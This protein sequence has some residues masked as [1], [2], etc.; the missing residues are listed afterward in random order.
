MRKSGL[1]FIFMLLCV[2]AKSQNTTLT[3]TVKLRG[4]RLTYPLVR[5]WITAFKREFPNVN[6]QIAQT[7]PADSIDL[8]LAAHSIIAEDLKGN[9]TYVAISRYVQLP[10]VN[11]QNPQLKQLQEKGF[12]DS[13]F[14]NIYFSSGNKSAS[15][16]PLPI[17]LYNRERPTCA[18]ITVARHF[19]NDDNALNGKPVKGDDQDL[20]NAVKSDVNGISFNNLGFIYDTKTRKVNEGI[21]VIPIDLN[22]SGK[23]DTDES[24]YDNLDQVISFVE[25]TNNRKFIDEHVNVI[26]KRDLQNQAA[27]VFLKWVLEK[28]QQYNHGKGFLDLAAETLKDQQQVINETFKLSSTSSCNDLNGVIS[29]RKQ[30][31]AMVK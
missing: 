2:L 22:D 5:D 4:T 27:G 7:A 25:K 8:Q 3:G 18:T 26:F 30:K 29:K 19:G 24:I 14:N 10:V 16:A 15:T 1:I 6:V 21:A 13:D 28:G 17:T 23:I 11:D 12:R 9:K 31:T 20:L